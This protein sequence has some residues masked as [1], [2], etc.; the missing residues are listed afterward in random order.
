KSA[1]STPP[2]STLQQRDLVPFRAAFA[3][4]VG[5]VMISHAKV[6]GLS[7]GL[8]AT[9]SK[10]A[11]SAARSQAGDK[12]LIITDSLMM[13]AVTKAMR[14]TQSRAAVRAIA[15]G[16]DLALVQGNWAATRS[17]IATAI[18]NGTIPRTQAI[19]SARRVIAAQQSWG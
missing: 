17:A 8:P 7:A 2:W 13:A 11:L 19:A 5:A 9:Q 1:G 12:T 4:G 18:A 6:P 10:S 3:A 14:Q 15:A 16:A